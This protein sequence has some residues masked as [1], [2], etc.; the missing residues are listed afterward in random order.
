MSLAPGRR[1]CYNVGMPP[2]PVPGPEALPP[3]T[4]VPAEPDLLDAL[5]HPIAHGYRL[6]RRALPRLANQVA[7]PLALVAAAM[8]PLAGWWRGLWGEDSLMLVLPILATMAVAAALVGSVL[9]L[10]HAGQARESPHLQVA[11]RFVPWAL[12]WALVGAA[13]LAGSMACVVPGVYLGLRLF[14]ADEY[15]LLHGDG[16]LAAIRS[17]WNMTR[18]IAADVL[19]LQF[20]I[21]L[22]QLAVWIPACVVLA[23]LFNVAAEGDLPATLRWAILA[24]VSTVVVVLCFAFSHACEIVYFYGLD[25]ELE[26]EREG[27]R[28]G[29]P[30][31]PAADASGRPLCPRCGTPWDPGDYRPDAPAILCSGCRGELRRDSTPRW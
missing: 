29:E 10:E 8:V 24:A 27:E 26:A 23:V 9:S 19:R 25:A 14:W 15:A 4:L 30:T 7:L 6:W 28:E 31:A 20:V 3:S 12:T 22:A 11:T 2:V 17:S 18:G 5:D 21:A 16:P 13:V 1:P